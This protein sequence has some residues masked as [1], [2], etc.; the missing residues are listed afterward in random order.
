MSTSKPR[1]FHYELPGGWLLLVG[2]TAADNDILSTTIAA[3]D[4]WWFHVEAVP[5]SHV[6]LQA[7]QGEEP[8]RDTL[9]QAAAVA[10]YHSK[11]RHAGTI[12]VYCTRA[13]YV[14]KPRGVKTGTVEVARGTLLKVAPDIRLAKRVNLD[15]TLY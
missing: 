13:R 6:I 5:G 14:H 1:I 8:A 4:D 2:A 11:A 9:R 12:P 10:A 3:P 15:P 7:K